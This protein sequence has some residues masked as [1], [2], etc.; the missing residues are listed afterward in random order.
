VLQNELAA[1]STNSTHT[2][3]DYGG[4]HLNRDN[5]ELVAGVITSLVRRV[6][7]QEHR[8]PAS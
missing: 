2:V 4:H 1:L 6:R 8:D 3:A 5:P 7:S